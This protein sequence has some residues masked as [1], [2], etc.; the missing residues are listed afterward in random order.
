MRKLIF[1]SLLVILLT[2]CAAGPS[3]PS[4]YEGFGPSDQAQNAQT[5]EKLKPDPLQSVNLFDDHV[6]VW[7]AAG[8]YLLSFNEK[9]AV[10]TFVFRTYSGQPVKRRSVWFLDR[11][12]GKQVARYS[13]L[14]GFTMQ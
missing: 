11:M 3:T 5:I 4:Y 12:T 8:F 13:E 7:V 10:A 1:V 14:G 9:S 6:E 2:G